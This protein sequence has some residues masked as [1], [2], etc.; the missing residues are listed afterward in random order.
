MSWEWD[1]R[2]VALLPPR[3][4][5]EVVG[6]EPERFRRL[7]EAIQHVAESVPDVSSIADNTNK[8][9]EMSRW[10]VH[11]R[12]CGSQFVHFHLHHVSSQDV[13]YFTQFPHCRMQGTCR[14][15]TEC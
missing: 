3:L 10:I 2:F 1:D 9:F 5:A 12:R 7:V 6:T 15:S 11:I 13:C 14:E 4:S 8:L